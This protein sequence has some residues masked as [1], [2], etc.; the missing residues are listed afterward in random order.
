MPLIIR[1]ATRADAAAL[2]ALAAVTFPLACPPHTTDEERASYIE[3][4]LSEPCFVAYAADPDRLVLL[5]EL[6]GEP[7][8][9]TMLVFGEP[10]DADA[11]AAVALRPTSER[12]KCYVLPDHHGAGASAALMAA[13]L[14][15]AREREAAGIWLGVNEENARAQAF[16]AK[17]GF[18]RV[19]TKHFSIGGRVEDDYVLARAL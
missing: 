14:D 6:D 1:S 10:N 12:S 5:A 9:Y 19:G 18:A 13:S 2:A 7:V 15:A 17:H 4:W 8:G 11:A 16:Y 3:E